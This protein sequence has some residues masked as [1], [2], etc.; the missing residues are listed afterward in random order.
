MVSEPVK[1]AIFSHSEVMGALDKLKPIFKTAGTRGLTL[2]EVIRHAN[3]EKEEALFRTAFT[4]AQEHKE[5]FSAGF[6]RIIYER[7]DEHRHQIVIE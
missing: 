3:N 6:K 5:R 7:L 4:L 1:H 2:A